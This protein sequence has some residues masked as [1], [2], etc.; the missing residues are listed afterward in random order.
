[1][2]K[3]LHYSVAA[4]LA[5][6]A[7]GAS[8][9]NDKIKLVAKA[10]AGQTARYRTE[11]NLSVDA[12]GMKVQID[13]K[14]TQKVTFTEISADGKITQEREDETRDLTINGQKLPEEED[15][16][17]KSTVVST[18][19]NTLVSF[20]S[21]S[22][23]PASAKMATR[24]YYA[25][26]P[27][28]PAN[29]VGVGDKW[30]RDIP[31]NDQTGAR[32]GKVEFE[33][34]AFEKAPSGVDAVKVRL[35]YRET[36]TTPAL[37]SKGTLWL[38]KSSGDTVNAELEIENIPFGGEQGGANASG[39]VRQERIAGSPLGDAPVVAATTGTTTTPAKVEPAK[40]KTIDELIKDYT[41]ETGLFTLYRKKE[42]GRETLYL[43]VKE[44]Q[45]N[46][47]MMLQATASTG[48][49]EQIVPGDP[50]QDLIFRLVPMG[51]DRL[52]MVVPNVAFRATTGS[53]AERSV[54][55][56]FPDAYLDTFKIE[57]RQADRKSVLINVSDYF[58]NDVAQL[59]QGLSALGAGSHS[60]DRDKT[61]LAR[62]KM[63]PENLCVETAY[64]FNRSAPRG[65]GGPSG[66]LADARSFPLTVQFNLFPL[67]E[68]GYRPRLADP[69]VGFF[70][71]EA[72]DFSDDGKDDQTVRYVTRWNL[73]KKEPNAALSEPK[74]PIVFWVDNAVPT[75]YRDAV[76]EGLLM[77]NRA[78][79]KAGLKDAVVV[80][81]MPDDADFDHADMRFNVIRWSTTQNPPYGAVALPRVNPLTGEVINAG[82]TI[83]AILA[84]S[85]KLE[86]RRLVD[87]ATKFDVM[88]QPM[89]PNKR[90]RMAHPCRC[91][92]AGGAM[93]QSWF[94]LTALNMLAPV[95]GSVDEK[96]YN[97]AFIRSIV[98]HEMGH[99]LG[100]WHNF[101][102]ST[103]LTLADL[104]DAKKVADRG[105]SASVMDYFPFNISALKKQG[106]DYWPR[107]L[108]AYDMWVIQYGYSQPVGTTPEDELP[109]LQQIAAQQGLPGH[110]FQN[111]F[112]ADGFDPAV[113]RFDL[114]KEPL[115]YYSRSM[116]VTRHLL[117]TLDKREPKRG[118]SYWNF[119]RRF[120]GLLN[121]YASNAASATRYI[122][123]I[124]VNRNHRGD[125]QEKPTLVPVA[126]EKQ[127]L[128]L[129]L[130]NTYLFA[131]NSFNFPKSYYSKMTDNPF[132]DMMSLLGAGSGDFP[133]L[134]Q[135]SNLQRSAL[136]RVF[137]GAV[138]GRIVNNEF[139][140]AAG[141]AVKLTLPGM[142]QS[143]GQNVW[144]ELESGKTV[145]PLRRR[146]QR[147]HLDL[148]V[149]M[150][151]GG[152]AAPD[153][154]KA[155][156][157]DQLRRLKARIGMGKS[158]SGDEMT[159]VHLDE[160][161]MR[162]NRALNATQTVGG[163]SAPASMSLLQLLGGSADDEMRK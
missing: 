137:N 9:A 81:Q 92:L 129:Q 98:A 94:G 116:E 45:L 154:A 41:K 79:E 67:K 60:L 51:E 70:Y 103:E 40:P 69:R 36:A 145:D 144:S 23:D 73:E 150:A 19:D 138:M 152:T 156:S 157:W 90:A 43:E 48:N 143:V 113:A 66:T 22:S 91:E 124:H 56:A 61:M 7:V 27:V 107:S 54:K 13:V 134:D 142:F 12:G 6:L 101:V 123:G 59:A 122:G 42:S 49:A 47:L 106:V 96:A 127:K 11:A 148:M 2:K 99:V 74:K 34:L 89:A 46:K 21:S 71:T 135:L 147:Q 88:D 111:D 119:T 163:G 153:D 104:G 37:G 10:K 72:Q 109:K 20:K 114:S 110:A 149:G 105:T 128:A 95:A 120:N 75:E 44:E 29:E 52:F 62:V 76:K 141:P 161:L 115:D 155:L 57:A 100:L 68:T 121:Q 30:S 64:H 26:N 25:T 140:T 33:L 117:M 17:E 28:F 53:P 112:L 86:K 108:G 162:I 158:R 31:V 63:F 32:A 93:D 131:E 8:A 136:R 82:I 4:F 125:Q 35:T 38:E 24:M 102:A 151:V 18:A 50:L 55:R 159:R 84:R 160:S 97:H 78:F 126:G 77:W 83:D 80:K 1:M 133:V 87:P 5:A 39:K 118:E 3:T 130:L 15:E 58:K 85:G 146:L 65:M 132:P 16:K 14:E 139:K